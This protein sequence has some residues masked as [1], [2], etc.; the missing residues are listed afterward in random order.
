VSRRRAHGARA[1]WRERRHRGRSCPRHNAAAYLRG[2]PLRR[3][4]SSRCRRREVVVVDDASTDN[5][6]DVGAG[7]TGPLVAAA[8]EQRARR[9][10]ATA[11][12]SRPGSPLIAFL[13]ADDWFRALQARAAVGAPARARRADVRQRRVGGRRRP[14]DALQNEGRAVPGVLTLEKLMQATRLICSTVMLRRDALEQ[15]GVSTRIRRCLSHR[16][17]R[18]LAAPRRAASPIAT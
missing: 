14:R 16:G 2:R 7:S 15:V 12:S 18:P 9:G 13:D 4:S 1:G 10:A 11:A 8:E 6:A 3:C 5:T 17:L